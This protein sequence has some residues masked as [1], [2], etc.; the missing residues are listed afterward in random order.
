[1]T[2]NVFHILLIFLVAGLM[3]STCLSFY[4]SSSSRRIVQEFGINHAKPSSMR[5]R[6]RF[7]VLKN[8]NVDIL[9]STLDFRLVIH[10][11]N[12]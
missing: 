6:K 9:A 8:S 1:M 11:N 2:T 5:L 3:I 10:G 4:L 7:G 12:R